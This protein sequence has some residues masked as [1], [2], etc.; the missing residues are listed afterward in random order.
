MN[1]KPDPIRPTDD[2]ARNLA[3]TLLQQARFA[4]LGVVQQDGTP[5]VT[6]VAF[7]LG[8]DDEALILVSSLALHTKALRTHPTCSAM[9]GEPGPKGDPLSHPRLSLIGDIRFVQHDAVEHAEMAAHFLRSHP[10]S[11]LYLQLPDFAFGVISPQLGH[12]NGGFG[13]AYALTASDM[14]LAI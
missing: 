1:K 4:A 12:L 14:G 8:P 9:I 5:L 2:D 10:K 13:K 7:G 11:K 6:R 3:R